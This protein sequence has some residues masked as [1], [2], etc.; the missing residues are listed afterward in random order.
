MGVSLVR[1]E[2]L[3]GYFIKEKVLTGAI[4]KYYAFIAVLVSMSQLKNS[5]LYSPRNE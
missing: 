1:L 5:T 4:S 3:K 2:V